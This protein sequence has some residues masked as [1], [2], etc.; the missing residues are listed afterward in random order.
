MPK[1]GNKEPGVLS[2]TPHLRMSLR[3]PVPALFPCSAVLNAKASGAECS[4]GMMIMHVYGFAEGQ[5][6]M[7]KMNSIS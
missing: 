3:F 4:V 1:Q 7:E 2:F 6:G 5:A